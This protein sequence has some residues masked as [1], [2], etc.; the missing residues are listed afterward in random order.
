MANNQLRT[1]VA[2]LRLAIDFAESRAGMRGFLDHRV[3][4]D[5][6][7]AD[8]WVWLGSDQEED[9]LRQEVRSLFFAILEQRPFDVDLKL[10]FGVL[11]KRTT[12]SLVQRFSSNRE[13]FLF[14][15]VWLLKQVGTNRLMKCPAALTTGEECGRLFLKVTRKEYCS[16]RC[17]ARVNMRE[18]RRKND[19]RRKAEAELMAR[20]ERTRGKTTRTR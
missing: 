16:T 7:G 8:T 17:Q 19:E 20:K 18:Q 9:A 4:G 12:I 11:P 6:V 13:A 3:P 10:Q 5:L 15:L 2:A 1:A 14:R